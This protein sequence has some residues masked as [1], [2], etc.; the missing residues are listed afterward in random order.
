SMLSG[1]RD[2]TVKLWNLSTGALVRTFLGHTGEVLGVAFAPNGRAALSCDLKVIK[3]W[4]VASGALLRTFGADSV[5]LSIAFS[6][7]GRTVLSGGYKDVTLWDAQSGAALKTFSGHQSLV[8]SV[9][10]SPDGHTALS[11]SEDATVRTWDI[12]S[13]NAL[14]LFGVPRPYNSSD[15]RGVESVAF[16]PDGRTALSGAETMKLWDLNGPPLLGA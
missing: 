5:P 11:G 2:K 13:G 9:A 7:D 6:P 14:R 3:L 8:K 1:S 15:K 4:D 16:S 12:A 10:F